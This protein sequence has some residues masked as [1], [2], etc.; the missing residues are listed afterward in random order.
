M[1]QEFMIGKKQTKTYE[2]DYEDYEDGGKCA[3]T[4][5][6]EILEDPEFTA[7]K[8]LVIGDWGNAWE[9]DC[10]AIIDGIV[11]HADQFSHIERLFIG[12]MNFESCEV[13]WI[14]QG[15]YEKL[16]AAMPQLK[17]LTIKG[18]SDLELGSICHENLES[19]TIIC[20]G[21]PKYIIK[22]IQEAKLPNL[23]KL[24]LYIGIDD[25]GFDGDA[26]TVRE[27]LEKADFPQL[28]Y[29]G[30]TDSEIQDEL[31]KVVL[32]SKFMGQIRTLD[33][34]MGTLTDE[35]GA[36]LLETL[37]RYPNIKKLD[38]HHNYLSKEM[39][40]KLEDLPIVVDVSEIEKPWE[41]K[42]EIYMNAML[43]E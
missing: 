14:M 4:I 35:S 18:S 3:A 30:I 5:V 13:S 7:L 2:Y 41:Y 43:T 6:Q 25:Y 39:A 12:D 9:D 17:E 40:K 22:E 24:L 8:E 32:E 31:A 10:Q 38:L 36:L 26:D 27:L 29:L 15:N 16:W 23:K 37:P 42:G 34:S 21:L 11:E 19:L 33:L 20:G 1:E 28:K